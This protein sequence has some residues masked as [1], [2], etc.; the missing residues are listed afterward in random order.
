MCVNKMPSCPGPAPKRRRVDK[1]K[2]TL[3]KQINTVW[4]LRQWGS[5]KCASIVSA[6]SKKWSKKNNPYTLERLKELLNKVNYPGWESVTKQTKVDVTKYFKPP[7]TTS[8]TK[9]TTK[10]DVLKYFKP[11]PTIVGINASKNQK[12]VSEKKSVANDVEKRSDFVADWSTADVASWLTEIGLE[13]WCKHFDG[14]LGSHLYYIK[15]CHLIQMGLPLPKRLQ[16]LSERDVLTPTRSSLGGPTSSGFP[17]GMRG[18]GG[19][20]GGGV[21]LSRKPKPKRK[22]Q[23]NQSP[24]PSRPIK[25]YTLVSRNTPYGKSALKEDTKLTWAQK[26][27][28]LCL[29]LNALQKTPI[30]NLN[31][32]QL[33]FTDDGW[34]HCIMCDKTFHSFE[35]NR[36]RYSNLAAHFKTKTHWNVC[37]LNPSCK[38]R[39]RPRQQP[40]LKFQNYAQL[41][42][43]LQV[44][45]VFITT[46]IFAQN[47]STPPPTSQLRQVMCALFSGQNPTISNNAF[48]K[49][50]VLLRA[51]LSLFKPAIETVKQVS[52]IIPIT[53]IFVTHSIITIISHYYPTP[54]SEVDECGQFGRR[55]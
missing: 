31:P 29:K 48:E 49:I 5:I 35:E 16:F 53:Q 47:I 43:T 12:I 3:L 22:S 21:N 34:P 13:K 7:P 30:K 46:H 33:G 23:E 15:E 24:S 6:L 25:T 50:Q 11:P 42:K 17:Q 19:G 1:E 28:D 10:V 52:A 38:T 26:S 20:A 39:S 40:V 9:Q 45:L 54:A 14:V 36:V 2:K 32:N 18:A 4:G 51:M 37:K 8:V 55:P 44:I 41:E 27:Y